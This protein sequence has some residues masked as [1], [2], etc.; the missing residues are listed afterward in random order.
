MTELLQIT[1]GILERG[2]IFGLVAAATHIASR[3]ISFD[4]LSIEGAFGLGGAITALLLSWHIHPLIGVL[5]ST[6]AGALTGMLAGILNTKLKLNNLISGIVITTGLFSIILKIAGSN[7]VLL[8]KRTI[9]NLIPLG[10]APVQN[11]ITLSII[12]ILVF[13]A[14]SWLLK[15]EV[16]LL[17]HT[18]GDTPQMLTNIGKNI[19]AHIMLGLALSNAIAALSGSL[20]VQFTGYFSIWTGLGVL[21]IG[22]ASMI[23][24]ETISTKFGLALLAG[25][26]AYQA[27]I[28]L[29]FEL[30]LDHDWN[31]LISALLIVILIGIQQWTRKK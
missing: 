19:D 24:A 13:V 7:M 2:L 6:G 23:L 1:L 20:F 21:I 11:L 25:A 10:I 28:T 9:L 5:V 30:Q 3:L 16:G 31:K 8:Q 4:N 12:T 27:I 22:L 29:T 14:I 15:T 26:I 17:L 18:V